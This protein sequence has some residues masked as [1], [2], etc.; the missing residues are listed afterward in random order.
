MNFGEHELLL[1]PPM[2]FSDWSN[3]SQQCRRRHVVTRA[4]SEAETEH[5]LR[6][7]N[8]KWSRNH[9]LAMSELEES[10]P[11]DLKK[12]IQ[13]VQCARVSFVFSTRALQS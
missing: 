9:E 10:C 13:Y 6:N 2:V 11:M 3:S 5:A 7:P 8:H 1:I 12:H 4:W